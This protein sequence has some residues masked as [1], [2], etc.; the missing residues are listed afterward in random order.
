MPIKRLPEQCL[1]YGVTANV[2][3]LGGLIQL[4]EHCRRLGPHSRVELA[5]PFCPRLEVDRY[6]LSLVGQACDSSADIGSGRLRVFLILQLSPASV[7]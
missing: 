4:L 6:V 7:S 1:N 5:V 2:E 3:F